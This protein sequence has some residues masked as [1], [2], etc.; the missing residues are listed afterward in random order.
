MVVVAV[1]GIITVLGTPVFISFM[2]AQ[3]LQGAAQQVVT[4]MNQARQLAI[5]RNTSYQVEVDVSGNQLRFVRTSDNAAWVG[6]GTDSNGY[7][8]LENQA[9]L[10][11]ATANPTFNSL[12]TASAATITVQNAQGSGSMDVVVSTSGRI[13]IQ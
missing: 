2:Q 6:P 1:I 13:R 8:Q 12:G 11:N 10:S 4:L 9:K 7:R 3:K 5:T